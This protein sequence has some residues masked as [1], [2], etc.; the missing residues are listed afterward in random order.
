MNFGLP[1]PTEPLNFCII[2]AFRFAK[3]NNN[4]GCPPLYTLINVVCRKTTKIEQYN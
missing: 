3:G 2:N 4:Y 1:H